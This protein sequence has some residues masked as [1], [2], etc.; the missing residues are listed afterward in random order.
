METNN[1]GKNGR[2]G[3]RIDQWERFL[4]SKG[5]DNVRSLTP[6]SVCIGNAGENMAGAK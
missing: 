2:H 6:K 4:K 5:G 3:E 1:D